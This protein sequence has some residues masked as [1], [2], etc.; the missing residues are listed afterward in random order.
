M[1]LAISDLVHSLGLGS[2]ILKQ[3]LRQKFALVC[4]RGASQ[5]C[6][7]SYFFMQSLKPATW[8]TARRSEP[9]I[10]GTAF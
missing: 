1:K 6:S 5:K 4:G 8:C 9:W 3:L 2:T 7:Y 10:F